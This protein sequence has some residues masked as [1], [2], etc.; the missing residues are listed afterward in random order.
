MSYPSWPYSKRFAVAVAAFFC[1]LAAL[2]TLA[3]ILANGVNVP[4]ADEWWYSTMVQKVRLGEATIGTFW[5]PNNEHRMFIPKVEFSVLALLTHWNSK[6]MMVFQW[7]MMAVAGAMLFVEFRKIYPPSRPLLWVGTVIAAL[8]IFFG[9][10]QHEN[11]LWAFQFA[12]FFIQT[13]VIVSIFAISRWTGPFWLRVLIASLFASAASFSSAQGLLIWPALVLA[14]ILTGESKERKISGTIFLIALTV[15]IAWIYFRDLRIAPDDRLRLPLRELLTKPKVVLHGFFGLVGDPLVYWVPHI[16]R[17]ALAWP[18]GLIVTAIFAWLSVGLIRDPN[19]RATAAPW[20]ALGFYGFCFCLV[21]MFGRLGGGYNLFFLTSRYTTHPTLIAVAVLALSLIAIASPVSEAFRNHRSFSR[22]GFAL[23]SILLTLA[24]I[25]D[26]DAFH[27]G[28]TDA[29]NRSFAKNLIPFYRYFDPTV[30]GVRNGPF[31]P[32]CPLKGRGIFEV[33]LQP[34]CREGLFDEVRSAHFIETQP[35]ET[36][37]YRMSHS[38][39]GHDESELVW[40]LSGTISSKKELTDKMLFIR[41][42]GSKMFMTAARLEPTAGKA[43]PQ[44]AWRV[45]VSSLILS[46]PKIPLEF[47]T[48]DRADNAFRLINSRLSLAT[49]AEPH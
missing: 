21:T 35:D 15:L 24:V 8:A 44:Y 28:A 46:D 40:V 32:L 5:S 48:Y 19:S 6:T 16:G 9:G 38:S 1:S 41:P 10:V 30:D 23:A 31:Y 27:Q 17:L 36:G 25:G 45:A 22:T 34:L 33:G 11:W 7:V 12:F 3:L 42:V 2:S 47:W 14:T 20:I 18:V 43:V 26:V 49:T 4:F 13:C 29:Q 39:K 37:S